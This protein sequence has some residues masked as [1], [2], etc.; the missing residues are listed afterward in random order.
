[1]F[2]LIDTEAGSVCI[3]SGQSRH[4]DSL[5]SKR[6]PKIGF[7]KAGYVLSTQL[8]GVWFVY[9]SITPVNVLVS[10]QDLDMAGFYPPCLGM[11]FLKRLFYS[12]VTSRLSRPYTPQWGFRFAVPDQDNTSFTPIYG[13][14]TQ[15]LCGQDVGQAVARL[16]PW[17][18]R[19]LHSRR[20]VIEKFIKRHRVESCRK[21][22]IPNSQFIMNFKF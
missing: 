16:D 9:A 21:I 20:A 7:V 13:A 4:Q 6:L 17:P 12:E 18:G 3:P 10:K 11:H 2:G 1:M 5:P 14:F 8:S 19:F 22:N 15:R